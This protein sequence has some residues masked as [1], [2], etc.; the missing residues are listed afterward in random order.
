MLWYWHRVLCLTLPIIALHLSSTT[1][2]ELTAALPECVERVATAITHVTMASPRPSRISLAI[3]L[4][5]IVLCAQ[6]RPW[7][8]PIGE[9]L[10][11]FKMEHHTSDEPIEGSSLKYE[12]M[13][14][15]PDA[16]M[17]QSDL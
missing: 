5:D 2:I 3:L 12:S 6:R 15:N 14:G 11:T 16:S 13:L 10:H 9:E 4:Q 1:T 8:G 7:S 17:A